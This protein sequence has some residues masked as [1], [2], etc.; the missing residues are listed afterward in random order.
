MR[1]AALVTEPARLQTLIRR[2]TPRG[3][4][5]MPRFVRK[6]SGVPTAVKTQAASR[7]RRRGNAF[8]WKEFFA[9]F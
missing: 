2:A 9:A 6:A 3:A 1:L 4:P 8:R 5:T 7:K